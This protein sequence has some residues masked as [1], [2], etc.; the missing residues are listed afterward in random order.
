MR[1]PDAIVDRLTSLRRGKARA[2]ALV[3]VLWALAIGVAAIG[4]S[5]RGVSASKEAADFV[6]F[7][8]LGS[9]ARSHQVS[10]LYD[11]EALR[12]AHIDLVPS[13]AAHVY[14]PVY[15]P[16]VAVLFAPFSAI[17][18]EHA[19]LLW[20]ALTVAFYA[21]IVWTA[22]K[23]VSDRL[24]H[25]AMAFTAAAAFPPL[26]SLLLTGQNTIIILG[27]LW[28]GWLALE[29]KRPL[30]A[31]M[32]FG[33]LAI[34]PQFG[35]ALAVIVLAG[36]EWAMLAGALA[37]VA[38]QTAAVWVTL[39]SEAFAGFARTVPMTFGQYQV[40][41]SKP[42]MNHSLRSLTQLA[43]N[44]IANPLWAALALA[45]LWFTARVWRSGAPIHV[46]LGVVI[47]ASGL[48]N[49]HFQIYDVTILALPLLWLGAFMQEPARQ[50]RSQW[51]WKA[52]FWLFAALFVQ[53]ALTIPL[54][55]AVVLMVGLFALVVRE[56]IDD[57]R[58]Q[59]WS[60]SIRAA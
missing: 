40:L 26:W 5:L 20:N 6:H 34:K 16:Q 24:P 48:V 17:S 47:L 4:A 28:A 51:Y 22:W 10:T 56:V 53:S 52:V 42:F 1:L 27:A 43:P 33:L 36:R 12:Q 44:W 32:A 39:G 25:R 19:L 37:S 41:E 7:Y 13:S 35:I 8:T 31:G 46:R 23:A 57:E 2:T 38:A 30:L 45:V 59:H 60:P 14:P 54:Y 29:R 21:W 55:A 50:Q 11:A 9:L 18:Y 15:P 58:A 3:V 49:P